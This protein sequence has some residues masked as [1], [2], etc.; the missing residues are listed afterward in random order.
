MMNDLPID[1]AIVAGEVQAAPRFRSPS[2]ANEVKEQVCAEA[3]VRNYN[4]TEQWCCEM[5]RKYH[6]GTTTSGAIR[7]WTLNHRREKTV[8][9]ATPLGAKKLLTDEEMRR[10]FAHAQVMRERGLK[11][12]LSC[13]SQLGRTE[14]LQRDNGRH[15]LLLAEHGGTRAFSKTWARKAVKDMG[16]TKLAR[17]T[18]RSVS[19]IEVL[20][21]GEVFYR[22]L[23]ATGVLLKNLYNMDEFFVR[24]AQELATWT[25]QDA[26]LRENV[27]LRDDKMGFTCSVLTSADGLVRFGQMIWAGKTARSEARVQEGRLSDLVMQ[28]HNG[29]THF[30]TGDTFKEWFQRFA[31]IAK[32]RRDSASDVIVLLLDHAPQHLCGGLKDD[33]LAANIKVVMIP[34]K[35]THYFQ[36]ADQFIIPNVRAR[37]VKHAE[38]CF[39]AITMQSNFTDAVK[40]MYTCERPKLRQQKYVFFKKALEDLPT[41]VIK[42]SWEN[43]G[44]LLHCLQIPA[45][46]ECKYDRLNRKHIEL[47]VVDVDADDAFVIDSDAD[48][49]EDDDDEVDVDAPVTAEQ[50]RQRL[51]EF[52][53]EMKTF[54]EVGDE[55]VDDELLPQ[56]PELRADF[57]RLIE[58]V[59]PN[60]VPP[61]QPSAAP[62]RPP[63]RPRLPEGETKAAQRKREREV[64]QAQLVEANSAAQAAEQAEKERKLAASRARFAAAGFQFVKPEVK[65]EQPK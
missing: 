33:M 46:R 23:A 30:Q 22:E 14:L 6:L 31:S 21:A 48:D 51:A 39:T 50:Y 36:P 29:S 19:R 9:S 27:F 7:L 45:V 60:A 59:Q 47:N 63:G 12:T 34:P 44:I 56:E 1:P 2:V 53:E 49:N 55:D 54:I 16:W 4:T 18:T 65:N 38:M 37:I 28:Q 20:K 32:G 43:T 26:Q 58:E 17:T 61:R 3:A 52:D 15:A 35:M 40:Q 62:T 10:V 41:A 13:F 11:V 57:D 64:R 42:K 24:M 25:W 8:S 5:R